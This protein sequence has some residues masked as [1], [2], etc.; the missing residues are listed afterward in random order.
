MFMGEFNHTIDSK[1]RLIIPAKFRAALGP[2]FVIT[3]GM[4]QC[5]AGYPLS[6]WEE[7]EAKLA[8]LPTTKKNVR[9]FVRFMYSAAQEAEFDKQGRVNISPTLLN[10]AQLSKQCVVV[11]VATHFEI[12][13]QVSWQDDQQ[14]AAADFAAVAEEIDFDF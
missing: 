6:E 13:D 5:L 1:G 9:R 7:L 4:D 12:W 2:K 14:A 10:Y 3:R 11:G 8:Q